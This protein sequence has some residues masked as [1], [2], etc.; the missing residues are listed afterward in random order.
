M[1]VLALRLLLCPAQIVAGVAVTAVMTGSDFTVTLTVLV[2]VQP[3]VPSTA[4][5]V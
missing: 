3:S 2:V 1:V 5:T 4:V